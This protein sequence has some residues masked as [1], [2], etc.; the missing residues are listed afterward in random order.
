MATFLAWITDA[1]TGNEGEYA[2][3]AR[4]DLL[5]DTPVRIVR[6][7]MEHVDKDMF[8][9]EHID[10]EINAALKHGHHRVVTAM[11]SFIFEKGPSLPF[12]LFIAEK[13]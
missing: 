7:F 6:A 12:T 5:D 3:D 10:Y 1:D 8:P 2:F 11:G 9:K 4:D 13:K